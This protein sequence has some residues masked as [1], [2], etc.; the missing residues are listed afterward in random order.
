MHYPPHIQ[1]PQMFRLL[2][3]LILF[4][5]LLGSALPPVLAQGEQT[6]VDRLNGFSLQVPA[7]WRG[8]VPP[9][10]A[11]MG[12]TV[13]VNYDED[14]LLKEELHQENEFPTGGL[15]IQL[16]SVPLEGNS[17]ETWVAE[18]IQRETA[19]ESLKGHA[20]LTMLASTPE[21]YVLAGYRGVAYTI[22][23]AP[24]PTMLRINLLISDKHALSIGVI[25]AQTKD[26]AEA[27]DLLETLKVNTEP[28]ARGA[29]AERA[30]A[31]ALPAGVAAALGKSEAPAFSEYTCPG[32]TFPGTEAPSVPVTLHL[33]FKPGS[34]WRVG[35][36]G[37]YFGNGYHC[38]Y[39]NDYYATDWNR[40]DANGN[41]VS[42]EGYDVVPVA[43]GVVT[44]AECLQTGYGCHV[45]LE[46]RLGLYE[47]RFEF[48]YG[49]LQSINHVTVGQTAQLGDKIG[50]VG[51]TGSSSGAHL[52]LRTGQHHVD[53]FDSQCNIPGSPCP[54]GEY[55]NSPGSNWPQTARPDY[56]YS[57]AGQIRLYDGGWWQS[58]NLRTAFLPS[59]TNDGSGQGSVVVRN[60]S[61]TTATTTTTFYNRDGSI[62]SQR[63]DSIS[64]NG[65]GTILAPGNFAGSAKVQAP[66]DIAVIGLNY[67]NSKANADG[68]FNPAGV[69]DP[70]FEQASANRLFVPAFYN[71]IYSV[72]SKLLLTNHG[73]DRAPVNIYY[74]GR[75]G[76]GDGSAA[77]LWLDPTQSVVVDPAQQ[78]GTTSWVGSLVVVSAWN[79][80][81]S[82]MAIEES[83]VS[84]R[85]FQ[86]AAGG[87]TRL[88]VP[89]AYKNQWDLTTGVIVQNVGSATTGVRLTFRDRSGNLTHQREMSLASERAEGLWL[90]N[91]AEL[92][93]AWTGSVVIESLSATPI[94]A[95]VNTRLGAQGE[96][97]YN[98]MNQ[99]RLTVL[100]PYAARATT[101]QGMA[102]STGYTVYNPNGYSVNV[103]AIYYNLDGSVK[104]QESYTLGANQVT[105]RAQ[106]IDGDL[107]DGW[108][109]S[110]KLSASGPIVAMMR[111]DS[112]DN[113]TSSAFNGIGR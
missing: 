94:A 79:Q 69:G 19:T 87:A 26:Y 12:M 30:P 22:Q 73:F 75:T 98:A 23:G 40:V 11:A 105:G 63:T 39:Y 33:P 74:K 93:A 14:Q 35:H 61:S 55:P 15:K 68:S 90:G 46:S 113:S 84:T 109:G 101:T 106:K 99:A 78:W 51:N 88:Y 2:I 67:G 20:P 36:S 86:A 83:S 42:D 43:E 4:A 7:G 44:H 108:R 49:H 71:N 65:V 9:A 10:D 57:T 103:T 5:S 82:A 62:R 59:I 13:L 17:F 21:P 16:L 45:K 47:Q 92:G 29:E 111:E 38:N 53:H 1:R 54:N 107:F 37:S 76:Y 72:T 34:Y 3:V 112:N 64:P 25:G 89:A 95:T 66:E 58:P 91:V 18:T 110:I 80:P 41:Y 31:Q 102:R 50:T 70:L 77:T 24:A 81:I 48:L 104:K 27:V 32:G 8:T 56:F 52:H 96:Y 100:F 60:Q 6:L 28:T 85:S 97:A